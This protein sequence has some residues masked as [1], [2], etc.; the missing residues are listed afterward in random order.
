MDYGNYVIEA[1]D[2][3][4]PKAVDNY[5]KENYNLIMKLTDDWE[6]YEKY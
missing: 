4:D 6:F 5:Y 1:N 3:K 2:S